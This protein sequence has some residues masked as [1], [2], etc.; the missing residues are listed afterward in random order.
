MGYGHSKSK[1]LVTTIPHMTAYGSLFGMFGTPSER[2]DQIVESASSR[3]LRR[4][5]DPANAWVSRARQNTEVG[6]FFVLATKEKEKKEKKKKK[7][8]K[9]KKKVG[10]FCGW[11]AW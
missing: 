2:P 6:T 10:M 9:E 5:F 7:E 4:R 3:F 8:K 1:M 11:F